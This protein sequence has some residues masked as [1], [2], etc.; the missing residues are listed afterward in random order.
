METVATMRTLMRD[1]LQ[2][3]RTCADK[4]IYSDVACADAR[5]HLRRCVRTLMRETIYDDVALS[6]DIYG[7]YRCCAD[8]RDHCDEP[9]TLVFVGTTASSPGTGKISRASVFVGHEASSCLPGTGGPADA[10]DVQAT[11]TL[12]QAPQRQRR[13]PLV[14]YPVE[15]LRS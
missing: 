6:E 8:T 15:R 7:R 14:R 4:D 3:C 9:R 12:M 1:H 2:R 13:I 11:H 5:D 10:S